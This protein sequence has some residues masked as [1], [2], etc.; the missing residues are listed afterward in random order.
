MAAH[1]RFF[2]PYDEPYW[3]SVTDGAMQAQKCK[4]CSAM[5]YPPSACC[6]KCLGVETE[7]VT[8]SGKGTVL[9]WTTFHRQY[10]PAYPAPSTIVAVQLEEGPMMISN[11]D[12]TERASLKIGAARNAMRDRKR[13]DPEKLVEVSST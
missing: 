8:L 11:I 5:R 7:W 6:P 9:S 12:E 4:S 2:S 10:L 3:A 1:P 13:R